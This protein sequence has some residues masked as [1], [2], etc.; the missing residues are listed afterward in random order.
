MDPRDRHR[1]KRQHREPRAYDSNEYQEKSE[2][3]AFCE[4]IERAF[5]LAKKVAAES[6][7][8]K[9][10]QQKEKSHPQRNLR[11]RPEV[12]IRLASEWI[13]FPERYANVDRFG[14]PFAGKRA[15]FIVQEF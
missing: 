3:F 9:S 12:G 14:N 8:P 6:G 13:H 2:C 4:T 7:F 1:Q 11:R 10:K 15:T 5:C